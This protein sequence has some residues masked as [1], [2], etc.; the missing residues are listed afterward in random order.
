M[1]FEGYVRVMDA[2]GAT[3]DLVRASLD[4]TDHPGHDW[5]GRLY[6]A[7]GSALDGKVLIVHIEAPG[8]FKAPALIKPTGQ[9]VDEEVLVEVLGHGPKPF[10]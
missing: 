6:V 8:R 2:N 1:A 7:P 9:K 4:E 10:D 5:G 3:L